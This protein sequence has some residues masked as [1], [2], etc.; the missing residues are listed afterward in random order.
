MMYVTTPPGCLRARTSSASSPSSPSGACRYNSS[1][2]SPV[3]RPPSR[4]RPASSLIFAIVETQRPVERHQPEFAGV[5]VERLQSL[6]LVLIEEVPDIIA[7]V[8]AGDGLAR[9]VL[10]EVGGRDGVGLRHA[11]IARAPQHRHVA[12]CQRLRPTRPAGV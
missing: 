5:A 9:G 1:A 2:S 7:Q 11:L 4:T 3:R 12:P 10:G 8:A 6:D